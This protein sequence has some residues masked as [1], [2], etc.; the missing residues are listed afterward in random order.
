MNHRI[1]PSKVHVCVC[2]SNGCDKLDFITKT[3]T[4]K[5]GVEVSSQTLKSHRLQD[6]EVEISEKSVKKEH[7]GREVDNES[8]EID[9]PQKTSELA[10]LIRTRLVIADQRAMESMPHCGSE[11]VPIHAGL[12]ETETHGRDSLDACGQDPIPYDA[13]KLS[14]WMLNRHDW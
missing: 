2:K 1:A 6:F 11:I 5:Q 8:K 4:R 12:V 7:G 9:L 3:G 13:C 14:N 10:K